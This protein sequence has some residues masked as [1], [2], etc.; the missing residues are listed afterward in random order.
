MTVASR[1]RPGVG[2]A[3]AADPAIGGKAAAGVCVAAVVLWLIFG[4]WPDWLTD[5]LASKKAFVSA[6]LNGLTLSGLYF[7]V[8][9]GFTLIF[10][11]MR[12]VNMA[13]GSLYLFG[14]YVGYGS[15]R[16][17][18][19][20]CWESWPAYSRRLFSAWRCRFSSFAV[21]RATTCARPW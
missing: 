21:S 11:L 3:A 7:L 20:G 19:F 15:R 14:A 10:G 5:V 4:A 1:E 6:V 2:E 17:G 16:A 13:H 18:I 12:N 8:A 9:S